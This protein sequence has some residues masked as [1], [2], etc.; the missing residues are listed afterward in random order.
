MKYKIAGVMACAVILFIALMPVPDSFDGPESS[1]VHQHLQA[2]EQQ[3]SQSDTP[4]ECSHGDDVFCTHLPLVVIDISDEE[5]PGDPVYDDNG[6]FLEKYTLAKDGESTV[7][8]EMR[9]MDSEGGNNHV[10]DKAAVSS[11]FL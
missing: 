5:I 7:R 10:N 8:A 9:V 3:E 4:A 2:K 6:K 1:R 11:L